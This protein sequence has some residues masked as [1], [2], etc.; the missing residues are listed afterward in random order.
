MWTPQLHAFPDAIAVDLPGHGTRTAERFSFDRAIEVV[1]A[2]VPGDRPAVLVGLSLGGYVAMAY[3]ARYPARTAGLVLSGC[4]I[5][6]SRGSYPR[7]VRLNRAALAVWPERVLLAL[8]TRALRRAYPAH[9][10]AIL[11]GGVSFGGMRDA[12]APLAR[13]DWR[14]ALSG[15]PHPVL[16]VTGEY[17]RR[18]LAQQDDQVRAI[19]RATPVV[20]PGAGHA[21]NLD[22]PDRFTAIV[23]DFVEARPGR[24]VSPR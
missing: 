24:T 16:V 8:Q 13:T 21:C 10:D 14:A 1:D 4:A 2:A 3:A 19:P 5:D 17:D 12:L 22:Q 11:A 6:Y 18:N 7:L 23:R 9:A 20:V 15:Y